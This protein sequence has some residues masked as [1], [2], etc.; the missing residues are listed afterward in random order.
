MGGIVRAMVAVA[1]WRYFA[2]WLSSIVFL[3]DG[4]RYGP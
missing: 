4:F 1:E 3:T 2:P